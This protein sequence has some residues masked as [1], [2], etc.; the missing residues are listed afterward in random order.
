MMPIRK[1]KI[2]A[3]ASRR[4]FLIAGALVIVTLVLF[5]ALRPQEPAYGGL[6]ASEWF[7]ELRVIENSRNSPNY[8]QKQRSIN[9]A[10]STSSFYAME[11]LGNLGARAKY[12]YS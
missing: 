1:L 6:A 12:T 5:L 8:L 11:A 2:V 4:R 3:R 10:F 9:E 7:E